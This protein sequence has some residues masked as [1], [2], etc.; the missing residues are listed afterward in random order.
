M[1]AYNGDGRTTLLDFF[2][3]CASWLDLSVDLLYTT[4]F[5]FPYPTSNPLEV[6]VE[7]CQPHFKAMY[8]IPLPPQSRSR[9]ESHP[10]K[11]LKSYSPERNIR[12]P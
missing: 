5:S 6:R 1:I 4:A 3:S 8:T 12:R 2:F 11:P 7:D 10:P 9:C